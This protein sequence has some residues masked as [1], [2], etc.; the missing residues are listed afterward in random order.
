MLIVM[1][2]KIVQLLLKL[3]LALLLEGFLCLL[4]AARKNHG[5]SDGR[6]ELVRRQLLL[7][8][9]LAH[10]QLLDEALLL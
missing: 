4:S 8:L 10:R 3:G 9:G 2:N 6:I 1:D 7:E 5:Q